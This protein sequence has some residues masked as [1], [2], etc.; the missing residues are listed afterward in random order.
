MFGLG[1]GEIL[2]VLFVALIF[3]GPKKLPEIAKGLGRGIKDF[4]NA[5][6]GIA[7][8]PPEQNQHQTHNN[9]TQ[10][11][12]HQPADDQNTIEVEPEKKEQAK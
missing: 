5:L 4:Q 12:S 11:I 6:R 3:I 7:D 2:I 1:F 9:P 8:D 10:N